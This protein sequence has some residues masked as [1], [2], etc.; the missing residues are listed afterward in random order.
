[1]DGLFDNA[2]EATLKE[3]EIGGPWY[4][5]KGGGINPPGSRSEPPEPTR[6]GDA[7]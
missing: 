7:G 3:A 4:W 1:M 6:I 5:E 2:E